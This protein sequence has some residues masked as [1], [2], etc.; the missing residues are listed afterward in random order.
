MECYAVEAATIK[1]LLF[2]MQVYIFLF[3]KNSKKYDYSK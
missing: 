2:F 1:L 3:L